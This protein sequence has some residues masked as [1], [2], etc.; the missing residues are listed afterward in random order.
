MAASGMSISQFETLLNATRSDFE[1][2][3]LAVT[4]N[5]PKYEVVN[6]ILP[7]YKKTR[8]GKN[9]TT[10]IQ[11]EDATNGG[12]V[13]MFFAQDQSNLYDTDQK[14]TTEWKHYTNNCSYDLAQLDI[15]KGDRVTEYDYMM[16]QR[17]AMWRKIGD[18][19][20]EQFWSAPASSSDTNKIFGP[21]SW[22]TYGTDNATITSGFTGTTA[23]YLDTNTFNPGGVS[24]TTYDRWR[25]LYLDHNGNLNESLLDL[26]GDANRA[27][28]FEAP[29]R[30][31]VKGV[32]T[33]VP[34]KVQYYTSNNVIKNVEK[35]ARNSDDRIGYD[36]GKYAGKT[37]YKN[38]PFNYVKLLDTAQSTQWG[39][40][41]IFA[42]NFDNLYPIVLRNWYFKPRVAPNAFAH[43]VY[44]EYVDLYWAVHCKNRQTLGYMISQ[45]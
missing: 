14:V 12:A 30:D 33:G 9:Y 34:A 36:L 22:L 10:N 7:N 29:F 4:M 11:L 2:N 40:D 42:I 23:Q 8:S 41:P 20:Q 25:S 35:I 15:N 45:Q 39:T 37:L 26:I 24:P 44:T 28:D 17:L 16:S 31:K 1:R 43:N 32:D 6:Q 18:D 3:E 21:S 38:I 5:Y 19:L 13:G 27:T